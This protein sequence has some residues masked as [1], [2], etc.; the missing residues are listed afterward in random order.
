M[1]TPTSLAGRFLRQPS[2]LLSLLLP[3]SAVLLGTTLPQAGA[4]QGAAILSPA[5]VQ[6]TA[7]IGRGAVLYRL[8][9]AMC[10]GDELQGGSAE[11]LA[12]AEFRTTHQVL[13]PRAIYTLIGGLHGHLPPVTPQEALDATAFILDFNGLPLRGEL[14]EGTLDQLPGD[15]ATADKTSPDEGGR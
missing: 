3:A 2:T 5:A 7:Q 9:C 10:H 11:A 15:P 1:S 13:P 14:V 6:I 12:G 8:A 4:Q